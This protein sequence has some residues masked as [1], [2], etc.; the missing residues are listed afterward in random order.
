MAIVLPQAGSKTLRR[1]ALMRKR[2]VGLL[3]QNEGRSAAEWQY[4]DRRPTTLTGEETF[5]SEAKDW[6][7]L[8]LLIFAW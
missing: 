5:E 1:I 3:P 7:V 2:L 6:A 4:T 8:L